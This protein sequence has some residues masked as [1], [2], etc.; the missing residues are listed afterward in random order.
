MQQTHQKSCLLLVESFLFLVGPFSN[1][2][3]NTPLHSTHTH[4][5][6][7]VRTYTQA[8]QY[9]IIADLRHGPDTVNSER[10]LVCHPT[11]GG[12]GNQHYLGHRSVDFYSSFMLNHGHLKL[13]FS[14]RNQICSYPSIPNTFIIKLRSALLLTGD[15]TGFIMA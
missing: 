2:H 9:Q 13:L 12:L 1:I 15:Q 3:S 11:D 10:A 7:Y 8:R 4:V 5:C 6:M 14:L